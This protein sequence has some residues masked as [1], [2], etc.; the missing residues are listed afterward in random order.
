[1]DSVEHILDKYVDDYLI[2]TGSPFTK[3]ELLRYTQHLLPI[4]DGDTIIGM[5][6]LDV[7][8]SL[9]YGEHI[10]VLRVMYIAPEYRKPTSFKTM[11]KDIFTNLKAQG[12]KRVE[13]LC[14]PKINN[15][16][17]RELHSRPHQFS[18][19]QEIDFFLKKL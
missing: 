11:V 2:E 4:K 3:E 16:F 1:M 15:W 13:V 14:S 7:F 6:G 5:V 17:R 8:P 18:H 12:F 19:L 9:G 10:P